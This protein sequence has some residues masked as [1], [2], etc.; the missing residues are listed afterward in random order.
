MVQLI[1]IIL[2]YIQKKTKGRLGAVAEIILK[3]CSVCLWC[4]EK[5]LKFLN[6]NAYIEIAIYGFSFCKAA[7]TAFS[8]LIRNALR[9]AVINSVGDL[10]I[11]LGRL[12]VVAVTGFGALVWFRDMSTK[13]VEYPAIP[14]ILVCIV[15][16]F[17]SGIFMGIYEVRV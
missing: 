9:V 10:V 15:A 6:R 1:R 13:K 11:F 17:I 16:Y 7:Q 5:C 3:C 12:V 14:A 4:M 2:A 8:L